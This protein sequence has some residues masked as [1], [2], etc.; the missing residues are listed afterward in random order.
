MKQIL[1][2]TVI[3]A[4]FILGCSEKK[5]DPEKLNHANALV[6]SGNFEEGVNLLDDMAKSSPTDLALKQSLISAHLKYANFF[7]YNDSLP[8]K[9]KYPSAL[10]HYR[11][12]LKIDA[13]NKD[14]QDNANM[15]IDIYKSMG[16]EVPNV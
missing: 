9:V 7:M 5:V 12:V 11:A 15:I 13:S 4:A 16:R 3:A 1:I 14:A 10:K 6:N 8:P 2:L